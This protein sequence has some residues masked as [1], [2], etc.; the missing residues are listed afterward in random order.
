[1]FFQISFQ[2]IMLDNKIQTWSF[3]RSFLFPVKK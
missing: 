1:M 3:I 2:Y